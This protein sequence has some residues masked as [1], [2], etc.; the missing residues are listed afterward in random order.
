MKIFSRFFGKK[1][2]SKQ[3]YSEFVKNNRDIQYPF[4][5][6]IFPSESAD[7]KKIGEN[8]IKRGALGL[9]SGKEIVIAKSE[10]ALTIAHNIR[11]EYVTEVALEL[12]SK[13]QITEDEKSF[14]I[15]IKH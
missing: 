7:V 8:I 4:V 5:T 6:A 11:H 1:Q 3:S 2:S 14:R 10:N 13:V 12:F 9:H 15:R